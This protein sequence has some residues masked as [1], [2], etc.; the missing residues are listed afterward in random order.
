MNID[1]SHPLILGELRDESGG[2]WN[3]L[4]P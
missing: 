3:Q 4:K 1:E 2:V